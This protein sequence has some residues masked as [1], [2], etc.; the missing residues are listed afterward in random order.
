[1]R[2]GGRW[3]VGRWENNK[4]NHGLGILT[5]TLTMYGSGTCR[6]I[7]WTSTAPKT[8]KVAVKVV[9]FAIGIWR[10]D[11]TNKSRLHHQIHSV[12]NN[13]VHFNIKNQIWNRGSSAKLLRTKVCSEQGFGGDVEANIINSIADN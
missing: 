11:L 2:V 3:S 5:R 9:R 13:N 10:C 8:A 4:C 7:H 12:L 1:M 6:V